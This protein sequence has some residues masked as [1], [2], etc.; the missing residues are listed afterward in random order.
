MNPVKAGIG[1]YLHEKGIIGERIKVYHPRTR[2]R[3][4]IA[5]HICEDTEVIF[6]NRDVQQLDEHYSG[7]EIENDGLT[8][9]STVQGE[10]LTNATLQ[11]SERR[12]KDFRGMLVNKSVCD[13]GTGHG[14]FMRNARGTAHEICG[15]EL[16]EIH[17][18]Y[19]RQ[20]GFRIEPSIANYPEGKFDVV[21]LFHVLE[22]LA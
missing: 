17:V 22:H 12:F 20:D 11:D 21:T 6:L 5:V 19:L 14:L 1:R 10:K 13:F 8:S 4:E 18:A 16:N 3:A 9:F 2:D 15:V 7:K